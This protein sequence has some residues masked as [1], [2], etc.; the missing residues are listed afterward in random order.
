MLIIMCTFWGV[1]SFA[2]E[3]ATA[4]N[5]PSAP[6]MEVAQ[7]QAKSEASKT[8]EDRAAEESAGMRAQFKREFGAPPEAFQKHE[9]QKPQ[10]EQPQRVPDEA[11]KYLTD[12]E[13]IPIYCAMTKWKTGQF[14]GAMNALKENMLPAMQKA[15]DVL[16]IT[17]PLPNIDKMIEDGKTKINTVCS[18]KVLSEAEDTVMSFTTMG[19]DLDQNGIGAFMTEFENKMK[20]KGNEIKTKIEAMV[21]PLV[22]EEKAKIQP[23]IEKE[24]HFYVK[25]NIKF[26]REPS[27]ADITAVRTQVENYLKPI[28]EAKKQEITQ[29]I[30]SRINEIKD[31]EVAEIE[32][33]GKMF[34][35]MD[36]KINDASQKGLEEYDQYKK[37]AFRLRKEVVFKILDK[38]LDEGLKKL[39]E[40]DKDIEDARKDDPSLKSVSQIKSEIAQDRKNLES[41]LE[42]AMEA[43]DEISF[44]Q[45]VNDFKTKWEAARVESEKAAEQSMTKACNIAKAEFG[46]AKGQMESNL[47]KLNNIQKKCEGVFSDECSSIA[48][49]GDR[50]ETLKNKISDIRSEMDMAEKMCADTNMTDKASMVALM[51]KIQNDG[52][53]LKTYGDSLNAEKTRVIADSAAKACSQ[54]I[55]QMEAARTE[56]IKNDLQ[57]LENN[58]KKCEGKNTD[59]C[60]IINQAS[61]KFKEF[62]KD[63]SSFSEKITEIENFC[64]NPTGEAFEKISISWN[65]LKEEGNELRLKGKELQSEIAVTLSEKAICKAI[66]PQ[67]NSARMEVT[68][69]IKKVSDTQNNCFGKNDE[70]CLAINALKPKLEEITKRSNI[71]LSRLDVS[72]SACANPGIVKPSQD[73][74]TKVEQ[75]GIKEEATALIKLAK[76]LADLQSKAT[77]FGKGIKIEAEDEMSTKLLPKTESWHSREETNPSWRPPF[78]GTGVWYLSRGGEYLQYRFEAPIS[79]NYDIW[80]RDYVD[81]FQ[82]AGVRRVTYYING[83]KVIT[84]PEVTMNKNKIDAKIGSFGWHKIAGAY[85]IN[86]GS[87]I[88]KVEKEKTTSGAAI[89]DVFYITNNP[90]DI[91]PEL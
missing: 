42:V 47:A 28:I 43:G 69:G 32:G 60:D 37:E 40:A 33:L 73:F 41:K 53:D 64:K 51:R 48:E 18:T 91:P 77:L 11:K 50:F 34:E 24:A 29:K 65:I 55:P 17:L 49:F 7:N 84:A 16:G 31:K 3:T 76:E 85:K 21:L 90:N 27:P 20:A 78:F 46:K 67:I 19:Q 4:P 83:N 5:G 36:Q 57:I 35:G 14:F 26:D 70:K 44:Q 58:F 10:F 66:V 23:E 6:D 68:A 52:E 15:K 61:P 59:D 54:I 72:L 80:V 89:L 87:N 25:N 56:I 2:Q 30:Q 22:E 9:P 8:A 86:G 79:A 75:S 74:L 1:V 12:A 82:P 71:L 63:S 45:A 88:L 13:L 81:N 38:N 39:D 62:S